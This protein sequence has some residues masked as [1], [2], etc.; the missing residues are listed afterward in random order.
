MTVLARKLMDAPV[1]GIQFVGRN[2]S[3]KAGASS[4]NSTISLT[5]GLTGGIN[6]SVADG[7]LVIAAFA[8]GATAFNTI[9]ITDGSSN[10]TEIADQNRFGT[11]YDSHCRVAYKF[12]SGDTATTFGPTGN[13]ND[14]GVTAVMVF[15]GVNQTTPMDVADTEATGTDTAADPPSISPATSGAWILC[16]GSAAHNLGGAVTFSSSD[17]IGMLTLGSNDTNDATLGMA[18]KNDW[19]SGAFNPAAWTHTAGAS[20][21]WTACSIA[22]RPA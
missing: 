21:S 3:A 4:G 13:A 15:R 16:V 22:L 20:G 12:V 5:S 2:I 6:S 11:T 18:Y 10:Y 8:V 1:T 14:A 9:A 19:T 7:D 17:L